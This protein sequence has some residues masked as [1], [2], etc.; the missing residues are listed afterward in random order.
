MTDEI[1]R[2]AEDSV[3]TALNFQTEKALLSSLVE[4]YMRCIRDQDEGAF[5]QLFYSDNTPWLGRFDE[6]SEAI[7]TSN[8]PEVINKF[9]IFDISKNTFISSMVSPPKAL[10][11]EESYSN[12]SIEMDGHIAS[13]SFDYKLCVNSNP[14]KRGKELWQVINT[15]AGWKI[16]SVI[17]SIRF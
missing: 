8:N 12:L 13:V 15:H 3:E 5:L 4:E 1:S 14:I 6:A 17:H 10:Q 9:G 7:A 2:L 16:V 11:F